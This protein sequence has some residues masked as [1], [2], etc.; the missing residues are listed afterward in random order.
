MGYGRLTQTLI[1][2]YDHRATTL[3]LILGTHGVIRG[4]RGS[5]QVMF[6]PHPHR[7]TEFSVRQPE[8]SACGNEI[9]RDTVDFMYLLWSGVLCNEWNPKPAQ[10]HG[11]GFYKVL[12]QL[13]HTITVAIF[14]DSLKLVSW[15][16]FHSFTGLG[17]SLRTPLTFLCFDSKEPDVCVIFFKDAF[18]AGF[19][20]IYCLLLLLNLLKVLKMTQF[21]HFLV[22]TKIW[23]YSITIDGNM[24]LPYFLPY[25][26]SHISPNKN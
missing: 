26:L 18:C 19:L 9:K 5:W 13:P 8:E 23:I 6:F 11:W 20:D 21:T 25:T 15:L 14:G 2:S 4:S 10:H 16:A 3:R 1:T 17:R 7:T 22:F 12:V 24:Q